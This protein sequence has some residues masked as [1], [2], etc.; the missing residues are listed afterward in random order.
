MFSDVV[1]DGEESEG[2]RLVY[3]ISQF[4]A[5]VLF[6]IGN[7]SCP[8]KTCGHYEPGYKT[9]ISYMI[10]HLNDYHKATYGEIA[11]WLDT[12]P[13]TPIVRKIQPID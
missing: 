10:F 9:H 3:E 7:V 12:L 6:N 1:V 13:N 4:E 8:I 2:T 5:N 11:D